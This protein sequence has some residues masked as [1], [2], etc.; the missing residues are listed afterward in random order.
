MRTTIKLILIA[1]LVLVQGVSFAQ[2]GF[3]NK[4]EAKNITDANGL[5]QGKW[6]EYLN[7]SLSFTT[8][9]SFMY[10]ILTIYKDD[11]PQKTQRIYNSN[12]QEIN[13]RAY[14]ENGLLAFDIPFLNSKRNGVVKGYSETTG[15]LIYETS[16]TDD[17]PDMSSKKIYDDWIQDGI[18]VS[19]LNGKIADETFFENGNSESLAVL[20][21]VWYVVHLVQY[22]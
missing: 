9:D 12:N 20:L 16:Y 13:E 6:I 19:H 7:Q 3:T 17:I 2:D 1:C 21:Q 10:Y 4:E 14:Y 15:R 18:T 22:I 5:K 11:V 8:S